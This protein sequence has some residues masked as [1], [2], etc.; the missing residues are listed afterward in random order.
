[1]AKPDASDIYEKYVKS[2]PP[3]ER[4]ELIA[5]IV[6]DLT[7]HF[8]FEEKPKVNIMDFQGAGRALPEGMD[9]QEYVNRLRRGLD[10][11]P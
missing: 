2:L 1:M 4:L 11:Q 8:T 7:Y 9:A 6:E 5:L 3:T 10:D